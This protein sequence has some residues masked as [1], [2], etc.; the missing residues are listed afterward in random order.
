MFGVMK[1]VGGSCCPSTTADI[2]MMPSVVRLVLLTAKSG[3]GAG[4]R[5]CEPIICEGSKLTSAPLSSR[6]FFNCP[7]IR[8]GR[9]AAEGAFTGSLE[10]SGTVG[11]APATVLRRFPTAGEDSHDANVLVP[12]SEGMALEGVD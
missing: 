4:E 12:Y 11:P 3:N 6:Q 8:A 2:D 5:G 1:K 9:Y 10:R 7:L